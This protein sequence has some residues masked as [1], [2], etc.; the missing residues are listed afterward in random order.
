V[1][2]LAGRISALY[3]PGQNLRKR[4]GLIAHISHAV[5]R[6][7]PIEI[8]VPLDSIR[9]Y[10]FV[11]DAAAG[12][13]NAVSK[14][15]AER[16]PPRPVTKIFAAECGVSIAQIVGA[17]VAV[18]KQHPRLVCSLRPQSQVEPLCLSYESIVWRDLRPYV[19]TPL[20]EGVH[21]THLYYASRYMAGELPLLSP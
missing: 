5:L 4:Q 17:F 21:S 15:M 11:T 6:H 2:A 16:T 12:I 10:L 8:F 9:D 13:V 19:R 14:L 7:D 1:A 18:S 3:G 20:I